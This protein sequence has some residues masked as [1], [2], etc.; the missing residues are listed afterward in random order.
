[1][2]R[3][4]QKSKLLKQF[5]EEITP[6]ILELGPKMSAVIDV[7]TKFNE[8]G[9]SKEKADEIINELFEKQFPNFKQR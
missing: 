7:L 5:T 2:G 1:M 8:L 4:T 3:K 6:H 9:L